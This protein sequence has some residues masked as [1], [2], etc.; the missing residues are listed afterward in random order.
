[1]LKKGINP[2]D[3]V[4]IEIKYASGDIKKLKLY[5]ELIRKMN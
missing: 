1:M 2:S 5:A 4:T 3:E